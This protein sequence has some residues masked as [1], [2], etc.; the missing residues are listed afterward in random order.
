MKSFDVNNSEEVAASNNVIPRIEDNK[1]T[2]VESTSFEKLLGLCIKF[3][4][5]D[6]ESMVL[7][8]VQD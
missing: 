8:R 7:V 2:D 6:G 5:D 1:I 4:G 3:P